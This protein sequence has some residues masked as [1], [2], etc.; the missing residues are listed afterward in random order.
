MQQDDEE[1]DEFSDDDF[2]NPQPGMAFGGQLTKRQRSK[3]D[4]H[5]VSLELFELPVASSRKRHQTEEELALKRS[6]ITRRRKNQSAQ[7]AEQDK[8]ETINRLLKKQAG[9]RKKGAQD[10]DEG[11]EDRRNDNNEGAAASR[12]RFRPPSSYLRISYRA[13]GTTLSIPEES[14]NDVPGWMQHSIPASGEKLVSDEKEIA[15]TT[16]GEHRII[17]IMEEPVV[18]LKE[19]Q[20]PAPKGRCSVSKCEQQWKYRGPRSKKVA[21][22]LEHLKL[23][24]AEA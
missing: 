12:S 11:G 21:C 16:T 1:E 18:P 9:K 2:S 23:M 10:D 6:E 5:D 24:E 17:E 14:L 8:L 4:V 19:P 7:R 22:G 3:L 20:Y 15:W 13:D